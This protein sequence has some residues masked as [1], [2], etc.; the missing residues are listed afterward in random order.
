MRTKDALRVPCD[1]AAFSPTVELIPG[2]KPYFSI[3]S[4]AQV[5]ASISDKRSMRKLRDLLTE[6]LDGVHTENI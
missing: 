2:G 6:V 3:H 4:E 1:P 5:F